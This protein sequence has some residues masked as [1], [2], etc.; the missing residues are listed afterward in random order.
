MW[1]LADAHIGYVSEFDIYTEK[2]PNTQEVGL[3]TRVVKTLWR[4]FR[5]NQQHFYF[6]KFLP[7]Y[8]VLLT[9]LEWGS[10]GVAPLEQTE[11]VSY[12]T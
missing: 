10:M 3:G 4:N 8:V 11:M 9:F 5:D 7:V 1:T 2:T 6:D 12:N